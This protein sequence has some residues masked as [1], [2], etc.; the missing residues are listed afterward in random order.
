MSC[1]LPYALCSEPRPLSPPSA[2]LPHVK[3]TPTFTD[4]HMCFRHL[5]SSLITSL[6]SSLPR[7]LCPLAKHLPRVY[8][9][10]S[11]ASDGVLCP[12]PTVRSQKD[13]WTID[14][15][16]LGLLK[17]HRW[18]HEHIKA[19]CLQFRREASYFQVDVV[20]VLSRY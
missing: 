12:L 4:L 6:R 1:F 10:L 17:T 11:S 7:E 19:V 5:F 16:V 20:P 18:T 8:R 14:W 2:S 13:Q 9:H 3:T 15:L